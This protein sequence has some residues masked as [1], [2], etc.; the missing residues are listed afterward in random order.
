ME[1]VK[2][3]QECK[4]CGTCCE[5]GGPSFHMAD[6]TLIE[7]GAIHTRDLY[8][9]RK[10]EMVRDN[11]LNGLITA[12]SDII[13]IKGKGDTW[14]CRFYDSKNK[15]CAIYEQRPLECR[16]L[17]CWDTKDIEAFYNKDR[18]KRE[19]LLK[20]IEGLWMLIEDH[21][22]R[23]SYEKMSRAI[24]DLEGN[25]QRTAVASVMEMV[26]YDTEI[27]NLVVEKGNM[28]AD[29]TDFLFG[30]PLMK[31]ITMYGYRVKIADGRYSLV[32]VN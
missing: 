9:I 10:G 22:H 23:C 15:A 4:R 2:N 25:F 26:R 12:D 27:R 17:T 5:K 1:H 3:I 16:I 7:L 31:T 11:V 13:K 14:A 8:T 30:R 32:K 24:K 28:E 19:D 21:G 6:K 20:D 29:M 18:L